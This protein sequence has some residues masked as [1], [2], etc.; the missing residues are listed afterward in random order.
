[1]ERQYRKE[2]IELPSGSVLILYTDGLKEAIDSTEE[3][4]GRERILTSLQRVIIKGA[5]E[6]SDYIRQL[7]NDVTLYVGDMP[8]ADDLTMLAIKVY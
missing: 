4:Y 7:V 8:Q 5:T 1:M 6:P 2:Q 3:C